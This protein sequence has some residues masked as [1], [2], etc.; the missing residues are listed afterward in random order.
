MI[1]QFKIFKRCPLCN[2]TGITPVAAGTP[3]FCCVMCKGTGQIQSQTVD[4]AEQEA[5][6]I[7]KLDALQADVTKCLR[8]LKKIL[9][10]LEITEE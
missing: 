9:D 10:K 5:S 1:E 2:G 4:G 6:E 3:P 7:A 8:R